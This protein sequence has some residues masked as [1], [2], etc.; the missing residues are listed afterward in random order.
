[1]SKTDKRSRG[2]FL[3]KGV[4]PMEIFWSSFLP[5]PRRRSS[6]EV[7]NTMKRRSNGKLTF[8]SNIIYLFLYIVVIMTCRISP[9]QD[10]GSFQLNL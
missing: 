9:F 8:H 10:G 1:M 6:D 7:E 3:D 5:S 4:R 2:K